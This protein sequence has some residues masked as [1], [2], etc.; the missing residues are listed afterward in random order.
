VPPEGNLDSASDF[1]TEVDAV[2]WNTTMLTAN[3][4]V[5]NI[6]RNYVVMFA[7]DWRGI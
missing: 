6:G 2:L 3:Y 4:V 5:N 1:R 7:A